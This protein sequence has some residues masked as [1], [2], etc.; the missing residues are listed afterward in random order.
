MPEQYAYSLLESEGPEPLVVL[1][2]A[3]RGSWV[4][5][6]VPSAPPNDPVRFFVVKNGEFGPLIHASGLVLIRRDLSDVLAEFPVVDYDAYA[7]V[8]GP[9]QSSDTRDDYSVIKVP[10]STPIES[11]SD[12]PSNPIVLSFVVEAPD[13]LLVSNGLRTQLEAHSIPGLIFAEP[14]F[15]GHASAG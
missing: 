7:A 11:L 4:D 1:A 6:L 2:D 8:L 10:I 5:E 9:P 15:L 14:L 12:R 3:S 13:C